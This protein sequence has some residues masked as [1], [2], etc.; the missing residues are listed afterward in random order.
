MMGHGSFNLALFGFR[1]A[2][3]EKAVHRSFLVVQLIFPF[4]Q[5]A[6]LAP[7]RRK[8]VKKNSFFLGK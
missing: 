8:I 1:M 4:C 2:I 7:E 5:R 3:R 6:D